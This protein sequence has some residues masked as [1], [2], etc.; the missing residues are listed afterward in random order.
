MSRRSPITGPGDYAFVHTMCRVNNREYLFGKEIKALFL[1]FLHL[2]FP[3]YGAAVYY[4]CL[5]SNH[6]H[7]LHQTPTKNPNTPYGRF[8]ERNQCLAE[9]G[10]LLR[11]FLSMFAKKANKLIEVDR[12][13]KVVGF[14][15]DGTVKLRQRFNRLI[16]ENSKSVQVKTSRDALAELIYLAL[17]PVRAGLVKHPRDYVHST[18]QMYATGQ[19]MPGYTFHPAY[20]ELGET[21]AACAAAF[22]ELIDEA[23]AEVR[24]AFRTLVAHN[25]NAWKKRSWYHQ[26][27]TDARAVVSRFLQRHRIRGLGSFL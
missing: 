24:G 10:D 11:H 16:E 2:V 6:A 17:N 15:A 19:V 20:L 25:E 14:V 7:L 1:T 21:L 12:F 3:R 22:C 26:H 23:V 13:G 5:M 9:N 27:I 4:V 8:L 18:Y